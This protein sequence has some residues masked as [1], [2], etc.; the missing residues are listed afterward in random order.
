MSKAV[1]LYGSTTGNTKSAA[2]T[3]AALLEI[4]DVKSV[5][6]MF[7]DDIA[8]YDVIIAGTSTWGYGEIQDDWAPLVEK[9]SKL[10]LKGKKVALF[11]TGDQNS[12]SDTFVDAIGILFDAFSTA[13][14][15]VIGTWPVDGYEHASSR[16]V[17]D[18]AFVGLALDDDN[19]SGMTDKR[20]KEWTAA[21]KPE[22]A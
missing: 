18:G 19:Q 10:D 3:I 9:I 2:D 15:T 5:D 6:R 13:G 8:A 14:A 1:V 21:I 7:A 17:K 16:A 4:A 20:I 22:L 12:Y 11:G